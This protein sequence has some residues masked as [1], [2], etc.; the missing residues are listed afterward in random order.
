M[1]SNED[2]GEH[3]I[4]P[5]ENWYTTN[6]EIASQ[7]ISKYTGATS[8]SNKRKQTNT[9]PSDEEYSRK[10]ARN[11]VAVK[12]S[13]EKAKN[14]IVE[15]Q[16]RVE[17]LSQ[18]NEELQTK[19][20][21]LT[22][23]LNVLRALFTNGG[24]ALPGELQI[25]SNNSNNELSQNQHQNNEQSTSN[26][27]NHNLLNKEVK[28]S[29]DTKIQPLKPMPRVFTNSQKSL[30]SSSQQ[31]SDSFNPYERNNESQ[32]FTYNPKYT[33]ATEYVK[34][35]TKKSNCHTIL[36]SPDTTPQRS[37][38]LLY[39]NGAEMRHTSVIQTVTSQPQQQQKS[40]LTQNSLGKFCIIQ[41]P[42]KVG[43]VKIVPLDS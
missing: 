31:S 27:G 6:A 18:E 8:S 42:E 29:F 17:Q 3:E 9:K 12:K 37:S 33:P 32:L 5:N 13:R 2:S 22:K 10:R 21:L 35:E 41:D 16:V 15:T 24:F 30:L 4:Q 39:Q 25:V 26:G 34:K 28:M 11:N 14:R 1:D 20:T 23:E 38:S 43:Q 7:V 19:V 40:S 36:V